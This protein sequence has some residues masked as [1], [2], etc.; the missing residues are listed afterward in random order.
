[1]NL[2]PFPCL[3]RLRRCGAA[4]LH[5]QSEVELRVEGAVRCA[6]H[7]SVLQHVARLLRRLP[8]HGRL[9]L[10][11]ARQGALDTAAPRCVS[12]RDRV[13]SSL[14]PKPFHLCSCSRH[15]K[16][17]DLTRCCSNPSGNYHVS[18]FG[19]LRIRNQSLPS[20]QA[21]TRLTTTC[22]GRR[23]SANRSST[24]SRTASSASTSSH[25]WRSPAPITTTTSRRT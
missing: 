7:P 25:R 4:Q 16:A 15:P 1:M 14:T 11:A 2:F 18:L 3:V 13:T 21:A 19:K 6:Q 22:C 10:D 12:R 23:P 24:L 8:L 5:R 9:L 20:L 17:K